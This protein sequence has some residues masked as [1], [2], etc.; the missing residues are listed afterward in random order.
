MLPLA[1]GLAGVADGFPAEEKGPGGGPSPPEEYSNSLLGEILQTMSGSQPIENSVKG[2]EVQ[3]YQS[4]RSVDE[5]YVPL[6]PGQVRL[7][8]HSSQNTRLL[9][10]KLCVPESEVRA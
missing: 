6:D 5:I 9:R 2:G 3:K 8:G 7:W 4:Q 1:G 10:S